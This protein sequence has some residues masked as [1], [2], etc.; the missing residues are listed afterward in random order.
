[1]RGRQMKSIAIALCDFT[2]LSFRAPFLAWG[3]HQPQHFKAAHRGSNRARAEL[4]FE[5][6]RS[7]EASI[8]SVIGCILRAVDRLF[9]AGFLWNFAASIKG[10][11]G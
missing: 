11:K 3:Y 4:S 7:Q 6:S 1:M 9:T 8:P 2:R 5:A 10:N